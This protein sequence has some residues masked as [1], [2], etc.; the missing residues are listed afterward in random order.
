VRRGLRLLPDGQDLF[1][2]SLLQAVADLPAVGQ[3]IVAELTPPTHGCCSTC[4][5][6]GPGLGGGARAAPIRQRLVPATALGAASALLIFW[7]CT[8]L[9][10][11]PD[12][13]VEPGQRRF[14]GL[15]RSTW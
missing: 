7:A 14:I 15:A 9:P 6:G 11:A 8:L 5:L 12:P 10:A 1:S 2:T 4:P 13:M 3:L